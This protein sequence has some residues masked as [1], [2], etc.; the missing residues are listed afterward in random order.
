MHVR[1]CVYNLVNMLRK[2]CMICSVKAT[3]ICT[4]SA[5]KSVRKKLSISSVMSEGT[6]GEGDTNQYDCSNEEKLSEQQHL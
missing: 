6:E 2:V 4:R 3:P 5:W 1:E